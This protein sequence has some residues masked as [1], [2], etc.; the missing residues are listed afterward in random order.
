MSGR[1]ISVTYSVAT[2]IQPVNK[3]FVLRICKNVI[4]FLVLTASD[5]GEEPPDEE[6]ID[7]VCE[8][9]HGPSGDSRDRCYFNGI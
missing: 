3:K 5:S 1:V 2:F 6:S 9:N 8:S 7:V 4:R